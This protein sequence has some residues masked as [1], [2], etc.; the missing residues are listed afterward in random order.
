[1]DG[2]SNP[3]NKKLREKQMSFVLPKGLISDDGYGGKYIRESTARYYWGEGALPV[4]RD[5]TPKAV[6]PQ[7]ETL[8]DV[9]NK[10]SI[11]IAGGAV[12]GSYAAVEYGDIDVF[13]LNKLAIREAK[14]LLENLGYKEDVVT[15]YSITY[16]R[17]GSHNRPVQV[18]FVHTDVKDDVQKLINRFDL[19]VCQVAILGAK[20]HSN[21]ISLEDITIGALRITGTMNI[22]GTVA[23][24]DKYQRRGFGILDTPEEPKGKNENEKK[25]M[26]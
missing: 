4:K 26:G 1:M 19:S 21:S 5:W 20:F 10:T 25:N 23:R 14:V 7:L 6:I 17:P 2:I 15:E 11:A 13:P 3:L 18:V 24:I 8:V 16:R 9:F 22:Y 12:L